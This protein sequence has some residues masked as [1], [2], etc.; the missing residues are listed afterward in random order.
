MLY[1]V[2]KLVKACRR[3]FWLLLSAILLIRLSCLAT[4]TDSIS[5]GST[6]GLIIQSDEDSNIAT[7]I[8]MLS[9]LKPVILSKHTQDLNEISNITKSISA[10][11]IKLSNM[12]PKLS[13]ISINQTQEN[14]FENTNTKSEGNMTHVGSSTIL[15]PTEVKI[16]SE[17]YNSGNHY[18]W[19]DIIQI[20]NSRHKNTSECSKQGI[21]LQDNTIFI[22]CIKPT[23]MQS[24]G[25]IKFEDKYIHLYRQSGGTVAKHKFNVRGE[26]TQRSKTCKYPNKVL[27]K[28]N[29]NIKKNLNHQNYLRSIPYNR[30]NRYIDNLEKKKNFIK[31]NSV[32]F[33]IDQNPI[34]MNTILHVKPASES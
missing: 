16:S 12:D 32:K 9:L 1:T 28:P 13:D 26:L 7:F 20:D 22:S 33:F 11:N 8:D 6:V 30:R 17:L 15:K 2:S 5:E 4:E 18:T 3:L 10:E 31:Y 27:S 24:P 21:K 23:E 14:I 34:V 19:E 25:K 29:P